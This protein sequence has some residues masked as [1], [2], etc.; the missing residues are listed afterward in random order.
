MP[1]TTITSEPARK[2][3]IVDS[4]NLLFNILNHRYD[5]F[6]ILISCNEA[7]CNQQYD[8]HPFRY[9][10]NNFWDVSG[11]VRIAN[12]Q[13]WWQLSGLLQFVPLLHYPFSSGE[14]D[15]VQQCRMVCLILPIKKPLPREREEVTFS[16]AIREK[17]I[18][19][20]SADFQPFGLSTDRIRP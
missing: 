11:R 12:L 9:Q 20:L 16:M 15:A 14:P 3:T 8:I 1:V 6:S 7:D 13:T 18:S 4:S 17:F 2:R 19:A 5:T 10:L